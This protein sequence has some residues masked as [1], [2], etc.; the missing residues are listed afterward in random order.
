MWG[1]PDALSTIRV[2]FGGRAGHDRDA[3][4]LHLFDQRP[5]V[6][7]DALVAH[8]QHYEQAG[9]ISGTIRIDNEMFNFSGHGQRDHS[10]GVRDTRVPTH[11]RWFSCQFGEDLCLNAT[12]VETLAFRSYGGY[13]YH[14]FEIRGEAKINVPINAPTEETVVVANEACM[15]YQWQDRTTLGISEFMGQLR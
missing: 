5:D 3:V 6:L 2:E 11:W 13:V 10:W 12:R 9:R 4:G 14:R 7:Q 15:R 8:A 1:K